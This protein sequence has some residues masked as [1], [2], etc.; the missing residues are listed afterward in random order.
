MT[1]TV[2]ITEMKPEREMKGEKG[3][4]VRSCEEQV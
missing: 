1:V 4:T 2:V 3:D